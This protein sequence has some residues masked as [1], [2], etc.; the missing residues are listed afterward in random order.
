MRCLIRSRTSSN[1]VA[2]DKTL[3]AEVRQQ[4]V[5]RTEV[6]VSTPVLLLPALDPLWSSACCDNKAVWFVPIDHHSRLCR[7][8]GLWIGPQG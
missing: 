2:G 6:I 4:V 5:A 1:S 7:Q 3:P 8:V